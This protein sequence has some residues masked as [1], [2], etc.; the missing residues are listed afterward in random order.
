MM[1]S[2]GKP[3]ATR[4]APWNSLYFCYK[5]C[6]FINFLL[7]GEFLSSFLANTVMSFRCQRLIAGGFGGKPAWPLSTHAPDIPFAADICV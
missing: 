1:L 6:F 3:T 5:G 4:F 7:E 2:L